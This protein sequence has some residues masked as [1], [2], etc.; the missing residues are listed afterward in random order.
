VGA[1]LCD[2]GLRVRDRFVRRGTLGDWSGCEAWWG[3]KRWWWR[4]SVKGAPFGITQMD[5][6]HSCDDEA[7]FLEG[8]LFGCGS[9]M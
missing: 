1:G 6:E 5:G 3:R 9:S 8:V 4:G 7:T 2:I